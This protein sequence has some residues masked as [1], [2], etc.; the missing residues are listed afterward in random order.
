[1]DMTKQSKSLDRQKLE[2]MIENFEINFKNV[3]LI[4][5]SDQSVFATKVIKY[6]FS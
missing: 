2:N 1:M 6:G 3:C 4:A 5:E